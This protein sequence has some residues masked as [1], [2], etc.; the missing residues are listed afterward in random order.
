MEEVFALSGKL[1]AEVADY[2]KISSGRLRENQSRLKQEVLDI[3]SR[4]TQLTDQYAHRMEEMQSL[5]DA[6]ANLEEEKSK[7][8]Q[9]DH[10]NES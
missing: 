9:R 1:V 8:V 6:N 10:A 3:D 5:A 2:A 7:M 4:F